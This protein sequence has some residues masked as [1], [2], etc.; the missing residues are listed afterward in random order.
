MKG[1]REL[2]GL[3]KANTVELRKECSFLVADALHMGS[4]ESIT[5]K[6]NK[7]STRCNREVAMKR[8]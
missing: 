2:H 6:S 5:T 4:G 8:A 7:A 3:R 1:H